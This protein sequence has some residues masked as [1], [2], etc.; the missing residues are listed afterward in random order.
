MKDLSVCFVGLGSIAKRHIKNLKTVAQK[1]GR[2]I[3]IDCFR[4]SDRPLPVEVAEDIRDV[5]TSLEDVPDGYDVIFVTNPTKLHLQAI[6]D[7]K[8]KGE[9]FFV[10]K[11]IFDKVEDFEMLDKDVLNKTIYVA[12][13][14]RYTNVIDFIKKNVNFDDVYSIRSISSSYLP[15]WR[16]GTDYRQSY[17]AHKDLGGGV[18][19]D[20]IHE[21]DYLYYLVGKP[22][23]VYSIITRVSDL[24]LDSNDIA[25]YIAQYDD[26]VVELHLDY[27]GRETV[28]KIEIYSKDD[29]IVGDLVNGK[30][31]YLK[32]KG[33]V[34]LSQERNDFQI[35]EIEYFLNII[36]GKTKNTNDMKKAIDI[37]KL[38]GGIL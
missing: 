19:I 23:K 5:Y 34:D 4:S 33:I 1:Q 18:D 6:N 15:D 28:R 12:C 21:W 17:S 11:P 7:F 20:L 22:E 24:E 35:K 31:E 36:D 30:I 9:H 29:T 26:K 38:T 14:L 13:P 37:L 3:Y 27:F 16:P 32:S 25:V 10:E 2:R 8:D